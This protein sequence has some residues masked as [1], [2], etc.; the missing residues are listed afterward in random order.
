MVHRF[1]SFSSIRPVGEELL[2][3]SFSSLPAAAARSLFASTQP[4]SCGFA[5][6][7]TGLRNFLAERIF[8]A[9]MVERGKPVPELIFLPAATSGA[10][11]GR[12]T[13]VTHTDSND[14]AAAVAR[15]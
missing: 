12:C 9:T 15:P 13:G 10:A 5:R 1:P 7:R 6:R 4:G 11:A 2:T 8:T 3:R 14:V